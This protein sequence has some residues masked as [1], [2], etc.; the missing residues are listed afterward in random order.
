[1]MFTGYPKHFAIK[2]LNHELKQHNKPRVRHQ[3][4]A[5]PLETK[6]THKI[7]GTDQQTIMTHNL[8][9]SRSQRITI[10]VHFV[11]YLIWNLPRANG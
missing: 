8:G 9:L 2:H 10:S 3:R 4:Q 1:M 11:R 5:T 7:R 6:Q